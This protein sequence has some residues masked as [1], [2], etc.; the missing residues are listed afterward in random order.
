MSISND[1]SAVSFS[2]ELTPEVLAKLSPSVTSVTAIYRL[3][4]Q[5]SRT[6]D[7]GVIRQATS[8]MTIT[9]SGGQAVGVAQ[10]GD[11]VEY[12]DG[13]QAQIITGAGEHSRLGEHSVALVGSVLSNGDEIIDTLQDCALI[14]Q[15]AG[16]SMADDFLAVV[17]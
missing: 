13:S 12:P 10:T 16:E 9:L 14:V 17:G 11:W 4:T 8:P 2:N 6:R 15:Q 1:H 3:A 5:G 7:G